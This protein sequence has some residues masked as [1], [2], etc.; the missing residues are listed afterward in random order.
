MTPADRENAVTHLDQALTALCLDN[1][2]RALGHLQEAAELF[3]F[4]LKQMPRDA[5]AQA[6]LVMGGL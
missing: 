2:S 5:S 3:G 1:E 6:R 4:E